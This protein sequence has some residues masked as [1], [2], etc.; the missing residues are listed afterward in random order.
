MSS[1][2]VKNDSESSP[3]QLHSRSNVA[4]SQFRDVTVGNKRKVSENAD[5]FRPGNDK[6][7]ID[8]RKIL[9]SMTLRPITCKLKYRTEHNKI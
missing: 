3:L 5:D 2:K 9:I 7:I 4:F 1:Q 8:R 6:Y